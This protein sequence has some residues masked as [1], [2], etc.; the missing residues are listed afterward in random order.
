VKETL[1]IRAINAVR[2]VG[3]GANGGGIRYSPSADNAAVG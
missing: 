2:S 3:I 1:L